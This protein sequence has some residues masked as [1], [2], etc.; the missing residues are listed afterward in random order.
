M[1][2]VKATHLT[3]SLFSVPI[4]SP[5]WEAEAEAVIQGS[6]KKCKVLAA[7]VKGLITHQQV[8]EII[9]KNLKHPLSCLAQA[10]VFPKL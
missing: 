8:K 5:A 4:L 3:V 9:V 6:H 1:I 2:T 7:R 10:Q